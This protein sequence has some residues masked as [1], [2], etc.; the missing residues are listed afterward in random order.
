MRLDPEAYRKVTQETF[1]VPAIE[2][3]E[4][5]LYLNVLAPRTPSTGRAVLV[6]IFGGALQFGHGGFVAYDGSAFAAHED[7]VYVSF[8]YR[9]NG[10]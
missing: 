4:D 7:V 1:N 3:S 8:N 9:T 2:E 5:C 6:W 10:E